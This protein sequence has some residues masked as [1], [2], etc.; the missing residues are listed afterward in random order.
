MKCSL[1]GLE[2]NDKCGQFTLHLLEIHHITRAEYVVI[3][4][5]KEITPKCECGYCDEDAEFYRGSYKRYARGHNSIKWKNMM[6]SKIHEPRCIICGNAVEF[7]RS[8]PKKLCKSCISKNGS[9]FSS[10]AVQIAIQ[11]SIKEK[12][13]VSNVMHVDEVRNKHLTSVRELDRSYNISDETKE[14]HS[15]NSTNRWKSV[16]YK[17]E[18]SMKIRDAVRK[19]AEIKRRREYVLNRILNEP[20]YL[21]RLISYAKSNGRLSKL[22]QKARNVLGLD[23]L[24]FEPEVPVGRYVADDLHFES[25][26]I[27]EINGDYIHANP[28]IYSP[29]D[30][31]VTYTGRYMARDKW[32]YDSNRK[33]Y[34]ESLG[35]NVIIV[36]ESDLKDFT[37]VE[38][39]KELLKQS[40]IRK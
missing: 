5:H 4:E 1:C 13:G 31:I 14:K 9:G 38:S 16:D 12:Y 34:L 21:S 30:E 22:H 40:I 33:K 3:T 17:K 37:H 27:V 11:H 8:V 32:E 6:Y 35:Y 2:Y 20:G 10:E 28:L 23:L 7:R 25:K 24:G 26:T 18:T 36:W 39:I 29:L 15:I 19:P